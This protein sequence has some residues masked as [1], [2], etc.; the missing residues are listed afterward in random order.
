MPLFFQQHINETTRL[1]VWHITEDEVFFERLAIPHRPVA[2]P[3]KRMQHLAGRYLLRRLF[4]DFPAHLI[5]IADTR[6]PFLEDAAFHFSISHCGDYAAA[7]VSTKMG[8]GIDI[9]II[10]DKA[11]RIRPKFASEGEWEI[12][13]GK[14]AM[15]NKGVPV[16]SQANREPTLATLIWSCKE[17]VYK[18]Y[19]RGA[20]DFKAHIQIRACRH[21]EKNMFELTVDFK[22]DL[23]ETVQVYAVLMNGLWLSYIAV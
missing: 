8:V 9:E 15:V 23:P 2:H 4:P 1:A 18:W 21:L 19:G 5:R 12:V 7:I 22:K 10:A 20:V 6:K 16:D 17:A 13:N 11:A 3:H 14:W